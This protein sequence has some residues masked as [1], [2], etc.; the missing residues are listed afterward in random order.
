MSTAN[1]YDLPS[2][3]RQVAIGL[4][5]GKTYK[6]VARE[7]N[8]ATRTAYNHGA[9]LYKK[10]GVDSKS[11]FMQ[12]VRMPF[13]EEVTLSELRQ[14]R[15]TRLIP[16]KTLRRWLTIAEFAEYDGVRGASEMVLALKD[17]MK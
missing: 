4:A 8:M 17:A 14:P 5:D 15:Y 7:L 13:G 11:G 1:I 10:F 2:R 12:L 3:Q 16:V 9:H 6:Q